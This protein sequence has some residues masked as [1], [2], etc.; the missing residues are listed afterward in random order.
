[1]KK[2]LKCC[3]YLANPVCFHQIVANLV[4]NAIDAY[5]NADIPDK[6]VKVSLQ[7]HRNIVRL[8][9]QDYGV[10]I[11]S[12]HIDKIFNSF[13]TTKHVGEGTGIGLATTQ[14][15]VEKEFAGTISVNSSPG[16]GATFT[17]EFAV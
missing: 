14:R 6:V 11:P 3:T 16:Q 8:E 12:A 4:S 15:L 9:V 5:G 13:F 7:Q 17:V 1:M 2:L 10:G